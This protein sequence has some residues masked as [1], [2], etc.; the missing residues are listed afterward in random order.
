MTTIL[1]TLAEDI[2]TEARL[3]LAFAP[4]RYFVSHGE[5]AWD[6]G[7]LT[8]HL[9]RLRPKLFLDPTSGRCMD[10]P[11]AVWRVSLLDCVLTVDGKGKPPKAADMNA[12]GLRL[13]GEGWRLRKALTAACKAGAFG[14]CQNVSVLPLEPFSPQGGLAGW[15]VDIEIELPGNYQ[16][17]S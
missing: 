8:V 14:P 5:P 6:C 16:E 12:Q 1:E 7:M 13:V 2:L 9:L 3:A 17:G 11:V 10:V 4:A 15:Y